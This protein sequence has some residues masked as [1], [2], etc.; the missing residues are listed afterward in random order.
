[1]AVTIN[2]STGIASV[3]GSA[4]SPGSRGTDANSGVFY[5][6]DAIKFATGGT[7]RMSITN[8]GFTGIV[9]GFTEVDRWAL[10]SNAS[11][12][13]NPIDANWSRSSLSANGIA[14]NLPIGTGVS[15]SSGIFSFPSTGRWWVRFQGNVRHSSGNQ[16]AE[17]YIKVTGDN[18]SNWNYY[19]VA[20]DNQYDDSNWVYGTINTDTFIDVEDTSNDKVCIQLMFD[21]SNDGV[22]IG[23]TYATNITFLKIGET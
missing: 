12:S 8:S 14:N 5:S 1:M 10:T 9:Q 17:A 3:D 13:Q 21:T 22:I 18:G 2:G 23:G 15:E 4:G 7:E 19:A 20:Y 16:W 11:T 6:S